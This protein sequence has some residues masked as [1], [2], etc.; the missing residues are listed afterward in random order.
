M[1]PVHRFFEH[2]P[3]PDLIRNYIVK[4]LSN[5]PIG[6]INLRKLMQIIELGSPVDGKAKNTQVNRNLSSSSADL[7]PIRGCL[8]RKRTVSF[9]TSVFLPRGTKGSRG[10]VL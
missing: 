9:K 6:R 2:E 8:K 5:S 7:L 1:N 4:K 3:S 10:K